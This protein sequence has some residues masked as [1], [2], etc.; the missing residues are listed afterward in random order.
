MHIELLKPHT[1]A[2]RRYGPGEILELR[3]AAAQWLI[4]RGV[5]KPADAPSQ[6]Q[7]KTRKGD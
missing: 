4:E 3:D 7:L 6:A 2:E 1:H 5:A